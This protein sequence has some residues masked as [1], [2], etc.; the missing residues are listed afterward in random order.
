MRGEALQLPVN[1]QADERVCDKLGVRR[2]LEVLLGGLGSD[3]HRIR[4]DQSHDESA[5]VAHNHCVQDVGAGFQC[6]FDGLR[7]DEFAG[8]S[9]DQI[10]LAVGDEQVVVFVEVANV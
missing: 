6:V 5:A 1:E 3:G 10:F 8:S 7:R 9:L 4:N 2:E